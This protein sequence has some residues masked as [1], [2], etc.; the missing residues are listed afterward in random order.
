MNTGRYDQRV[1]FITFE[2]DSDGHGGTT[3]NPPR[4]TLLETFASVQQVKSSNA[5]EQLQDVLNQ[6]YKIQVQYRTGF[7]PNVGMII[8]YRGEDMTISQV[9]LNKERHRRFWTITA[10]YGNNTN[11]DQGS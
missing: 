9:D 1:S 6:A 3:A 10:T 2:N 4:T 8:E 5:L 7:E 11:A